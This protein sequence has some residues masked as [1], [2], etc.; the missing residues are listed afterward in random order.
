MGL[1]TRNLDDRKFQDI[2][3][4]AKK[5]IAATCPAWTDH[6]VSDP[7][8][9][10]VE[11]FSW[12]T[13][14]ILYRVNQVPEKNYIKFMELLGL[15]LREPEPAR[16]ETT[17][18][19]SSPQPQKLTIP[20]G[21][22]VATVR[23]ENNPSII[24]S[25]DEDADIDPPQL[26]A[27]ITTRAADSPGEKTPAP[28]VHN[29]QH[30]GV[31]NFDLAVFGNPTRIG[32]AIYFGF[33]ND[34]SNHVLGLEVSCLTATGL[35]IDPANPPWTWEGW[36]GG[37]GNQRWLPAIV[38]E[39]TTGGMNQTGI[40][41]VRLPKLALRDFGKRRAYWVRCR[42]SEP[43]IKGTEYEKSPRISNLGVQSWGVSVWAT[44]ASLVHNESL[45]RSDGSPGGVFSVE[46]TP[47]LRRL[48]RETIETRSPGAD[49]W[50]PWIEVD[51]FADSGA[52]DH[53]FT[54][55]STSGEIRFGP[56]LRQPDGSVRSYGA[57]PARGADIRF[58]IYRF[59]GGVAGNVQA[60][61]LSVLKTSIPY[62]DKVV[63]HADATGGID[64]ETIERAQL[65]APQLLRSRGRA[66]TAADY[67]ALTEQLADSRVQRS[68]C[69]QPTAGGSSEGPLAGQIYV[70]LVPKV[71]HPEGNISPEQL[72]LPED[73]RDSVKRYLDDY[74]LL[75]V[76]VEIREPEYL[77]VAV[78]I[79]ISASS[80]ADPQRVRQDVEKQLYRYL[81][82]ITGGPGGAGWPFGRDLYPS[83]VYTCLQS[84]RGIEFIESLHLYVV[85]SAT[86]RS[87]ITGRF[88]VPIHG[89]IAS[90]EHKVDVH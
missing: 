39:D 56:A 22:E 27:L 78:D 64:A 85:R 37:E 20:K 84:I 77:W 40:I 75:T 35:G 48:K 38:E 18:Y 66:V 50:E 12:M 5:R 82:P 74:R 69:V 89:L 41:R 62:I 42:V 80:S 81:N 21:T 2:V 67:E 51:D 61:T 83:D 55:D 44:H 90:G 31:A 58:A 25:T 86:D 1:P 63:N 57:I 3:D 29:L 60:G 76:R 11:L 72:R 24:F 13:E 10:L 33:E 47:M 54:C 23:T 8:I 26:N 15:K 32:D 16:T 36:H 9:T 4:E 28:K 19:L 88:A 87:E 30:L 46:H 7:G 45:G 79:S 59:G 65:R 17:F 73:L 34:L 43:E 53:H 70:L 6:N 68:R 52:Q 49:Y 71:N 14:M